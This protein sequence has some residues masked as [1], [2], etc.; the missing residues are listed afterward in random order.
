MKKTSE[1][2]PKTLKEENKNSSVYFT[3]MKGKKEYKEY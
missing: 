3:D 1:I 2:T